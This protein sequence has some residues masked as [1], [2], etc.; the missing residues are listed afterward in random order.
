MGNA[1][2]SPMCRRAVIFRCPTP[3]AG[4]ADI[5]VIQTAI[6]MIEQYGPAAETQA[7]LN[8]EKAFQDGDA[9]LEEAWKRVVAAIQQMKASN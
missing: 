5:D 2:L 9:E 4:M 3:G 7:K 6:L 1:A 8:V